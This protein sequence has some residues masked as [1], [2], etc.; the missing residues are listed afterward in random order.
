M[1]LGSAEDRSA[2]RSIPIFIVITALT[3]GTAI[4]LSRSVF[5]API[6]TVDS[7]SAPCLS[8]TQYAGAIAPTV[9]LNLTFVLD[10]TVPLGG[11]KQKVKWIEFDVLYA[12]DLQPKAAL[13]FPAQVRSG[14]S[15]AQD[16]RDGGEVAY[17]TKISVNLGSTVE[18]SVGYLLAYDGSQG[19][20]KALL[21]ADVHFDC[22][23][24]D[25]RRVVWRSTKTILAAGVSASC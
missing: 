12:S 9:A 14:S 24:Y 11:D 16:G 8:V 1:G 7:S 23:G 6:V 15:L 21:T 25:C 20:F 18:S 5:G 3:L 10:L 19:Q 2:Y 17:E 13:W 4:F 22:D